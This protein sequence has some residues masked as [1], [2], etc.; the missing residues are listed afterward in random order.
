VGVVPVTM[1]DRTEAI[2][3]ELERVA[4]EL[5]TGD[6]AVYGYRIQREPR[7]RERG[8]VAYSGGWLAFDVEHPD[9]W[10]GEGAGDGP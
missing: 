9:G 4:A 3:S 2:A 6:A 7:E 5:R 1:T 10:F 8:A